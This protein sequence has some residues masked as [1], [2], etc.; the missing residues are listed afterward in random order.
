MCEPTSQRATVPPPNAPPGLDELKAAGLLDARLPPGF[1]VPAPSD[2]IADDEDPIGEDDAEFHQDF[3]EG[4]EEEPGA[5]EEAGEPEGAL[6]T[7]APAE[8]GG[9]EAELPEETEKDDATSV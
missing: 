8:I 2:E 4:A 9:A 3:L 1:A 5:E 7:A 6:D